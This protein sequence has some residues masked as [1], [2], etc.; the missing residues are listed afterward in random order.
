VSGPPALLVDGLTVDFGPARVLNNVSLTVERG[1][2]V[3]LAGV[4]GAGKSTLI[5]AVMALLPRSTTVRGRIEIAGHSVMGLTERDM[6]RIRGSLVSMIPQDQYGWFNP[7][8]RVGPQLVETIRAH[9]KVSRLGA[10]QRASELMGKAGLPTD[11]SVLRAFPHQLSGG[12]R[13]RA[14]IASALAGEPALLVADEP[15]SALDAVIASRIGEL[16]KNLRSDGRGMLV[17]SHDANVLTKL[18]DRVVKLQAGEIVPGKVVARPASAVVS[19][20]ESLSNDESLPVELR[21]VTKRFRATVAVKDVSL[22]VASGE[23]VGLIGESGSGKTTIARLICGLEPPTSGCVMLQSSAAEELSRS[24]RAA[25]V[26]MVFQDSSGS[27]DPRLSVQETIGEPLATTGMRPSD[28]AAKVNDLLN[29]VG[30]DSSYLLRHPH[31]LSGG[32]RQ[33]V[34]IARALISSPALVVLD[35]PTSAL[36]VDTR[37]EILALL[38][39]IQAERSVSFLIISHDL[40]VVRSVAHR[41]AVIRNGVIVEM[42][43]TNTVLSKP[44]HAYT[45]EL[46]AAAIA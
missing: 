16:L 6:R 2:V 11:D 4:S 38:V 40:N 5:H 36:D 1:E 29:L 19:A 18:C 32:Q 9:D 45:R 43:D 42:G 15:T 31:E 39:R 46:C 14:A 7:V 17:V 41:V 26:S 23:T 3:G 34:G 37:A 28:V 10:R 44:K 12:M 30:M 22:S 27:L 25:R 24:Q 35:E 20:T 33:R 21:N 8:R 13:Q